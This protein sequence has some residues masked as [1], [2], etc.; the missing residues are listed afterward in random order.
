MKK[1][2]VDLGKDFKASMPSEKDMKEEMMY[3]SF[4]A[5]VKDKLDLPYEG[6]LTIRYC[7]R[8]SE[9]RTDPDGDE[10]YSCEIQVKELLSVEA[11]KNSEAPSKSHSKDSED[12]LDKLA[13]KR[14]ESKE[15]Y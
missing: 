10:H 13:H 3:P 7:K 9:H 6:I 14:A 12:A 2:N 5:D 4:R 1:L 8:S 11:D 15:E